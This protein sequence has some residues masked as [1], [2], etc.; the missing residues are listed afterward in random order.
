MGIDHRGCNYDLTGYFVRAKTLGR[1]AAQAAARGGLSTTVDRDLPLVREPL[2]QLQSAILRHGILHAALLRLDLL[3]VSI[4]A[5]VLRESLRVFLGQPGIQLRLSRIP[6]ALP[7][8]P[9]AAWNLFEIETGTLPRV[10]TGGNR[11]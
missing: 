9:R 7:A 10:F 2:L 11:L 8:Q 4:L 6:A 5:V 3:F 1:G